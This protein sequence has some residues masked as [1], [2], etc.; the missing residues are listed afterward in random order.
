MPGLIEGSML[1][2]R[3]AVTAAE[4]AFIAGLT[5]KDINRLVDEAVMPEALV[6]R[7]E[8]RRFAPLVGPFAKFYFEMSNEL[9]K[10]ARTYV[11]VTLTNRLL[12]RPERD[13]LLALAWSDANQRFDWSVSYQALTVELKSYMR[14]VWSRVEL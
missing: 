7:I 14:D 12:D 5:D 1:T 11:L 2:A 3:N 9:T 4:A 6:I 10:S 13:E 8:G